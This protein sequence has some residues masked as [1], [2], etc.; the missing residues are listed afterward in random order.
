MR[1]SLRKPVHRLTLVLAVAGALGGDA[2]AAPP[3]EVALR[4]DPRTMS[5]APLPV[6]AA[7][8]RRPSRRA[9]RRALRRGTVEPAP[10]AARPAAATPAPTPAIVPVVPVA[11]P[12]V[13]ERGTVAHRDL[14]YGS[15]EHARQRFD[16][17]I[18]D[19]CAGGGLPLV[20]WIH[21]PDWRGG[22]K[23]DCPLGWLVEEGY[24]VASIDYRPTDVAVYPAQFD[25]CR[26]ALAT[27]VA[28]AATWGVDPA[29]ICVAGRGAGGHLAALVAF[30]PPANGPVRTTDSMATEPPAPAAAALVGA[31]VQLAALGPAHDR[32]GSA[33]SRLVGG[34]LPEFREAA[35]RASPLSHVSADD[36]PT[37]ILHGRHDDTVPPEQATL[38]GQAL[39]GVGVEHTLVML[40]E[41]SLSR[42][43]PGGVAL[44][45]FLDRTLGPG[46]ARKPEQ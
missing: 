34:P 28:D 20:V 5:D 26:A 46:A 23:A 6:E 4:N 3:V 27:L 45:E 39:A 25:D 7:P 42:G 38:L 41:P 37:L 17:L 15:G 22:S 33:A 29:R 43:S 18:P 19:G 8:A 16:M 32:A 35:L 24:A 11:E 9:Q 36:P 2:P 30:E 1:G 12:A 21:G 31:P 44:V 10:P 40:D 14:P 13:E